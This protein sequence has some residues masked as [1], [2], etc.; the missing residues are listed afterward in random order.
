MISAIIGLPGVGKSLLC[1]YL[2]HRFV[3]GKTLNFRGFN[4][5]RDCRGDRLYTN[6]PCSGAYKLDF[7][8]L[9]IADYKDA[10]MLCDEIQLFADS[11]NFKTFGDN[12][13]E[14]FTTHRKDHIDFVYCTQD[15]S[16]VDK[17]IRAVTDR[18][19]YVD[20]SSNM[21]KQLQETWKEAF[22]YMGNIALK[23]FQPVLKTT[24][25]ISL[26]IKDVFKYVAEIMD[27]TTKEYNQDNY[28]MFQVIHFFNHFAYI[29]LNYQVKILVIE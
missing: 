2:G 9:G 29:F 26:A 21:I 20:S 1:S 15:F 18:I 24:L 25:S 12:L 17:R 19:Y 8:K 5:Q 28:I 7:D 14:W 22:V 6:Y 13:T 3:E 11:R 27:A 4:V 10:F 16:M 23:Y